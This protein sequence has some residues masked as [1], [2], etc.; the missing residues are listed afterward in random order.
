MDR[1]KEFRSSENAQL[2]ISFKSFKP[3]T[4][5]TLARW[6]KEVLKMSGVNTNHY[7][8]HSFRGAGLSEAY[9]KGASL[10]QIIEAGNWSSAETFKRFYLAPNSSS[11]VGRL[12]LEDQ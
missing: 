8:A 4:K 2:F 12:I 3:V 11:A 6:L 1:T 9:H 7:K 5:Q 10:N